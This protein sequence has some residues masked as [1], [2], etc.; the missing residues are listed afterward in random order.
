[1][2]GR[3]LDTQQLVAP[4]TTASG[5]YQALANANTD[6]GGIAIPDGAVSVVIFFETSTSDPTLIRGR[7]GFNAS[8]TAVSSITGTDT[9]LGYQPPVPVEYRIPADATHL[10]VACATAG[11]VCRGM[12]LY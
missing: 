10:H 6:P 5:L 2:S 3:I 7:V 1:M 11:A 4:N 9:I 8:A 12:W